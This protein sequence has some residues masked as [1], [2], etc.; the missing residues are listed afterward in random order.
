MSSAD[1]TGAA[2]IT[3]VIEVRRG[4]GE[5][6]ENEE[7]RGREEGERRE[8]GGGQVN[9]KGIPPTEPTSYDLM[10]NL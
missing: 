8:G 7:E 2:P 3:E 6:G 4:E 9:A 5:R 10:T 1:A